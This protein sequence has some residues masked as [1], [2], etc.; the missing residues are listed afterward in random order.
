VLFDPVH[1]Y[2]YRVYREFTYGCPGP[3]LALMLP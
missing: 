3:G 1:E 2:D